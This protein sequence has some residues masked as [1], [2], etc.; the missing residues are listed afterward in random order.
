MDV[1]SVEPNKL[2]ERVAKELEKMKEL[3]PPEW[4][5]F[6][7]TGVHKERPPEQRNWWYI[8]AAA[9]LRKIYIYGPVGVSRL[10]TAFGGKKNRGAKPERTYKGSGSIIRKILQQL[11]NA[12]LVETQN[13]KGRVVTKKGRE[14]LEKIAKEVGV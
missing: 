14:F 5:K 13:K 12:G 3:Q 7:K 6:V 4:A 10:R 11:E 8:R 2:I 1:R 9:I